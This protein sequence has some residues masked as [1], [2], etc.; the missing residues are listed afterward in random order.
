MKKER[1]L[2]EN[3]GL[4]NTFKKFKLKNYLNKTFLK[5]KSFIFLKFKD[6]KL[7]NVLAFKR[8]TFLKKSNKFVCDNIFLKNF[9][10]ITL[11]SFNIKKSLYKSILIFIK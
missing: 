7:K 6:K 1:N 11:N 3:K 5:K 9:S 4:I 8:N 10:K 2:I